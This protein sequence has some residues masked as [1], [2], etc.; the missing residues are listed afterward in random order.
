MNKRADFHSV[1]CLSRYPCITNSKTKP[2]STMT[3][4]ALLLASFSELHSIGGTMFMYPLSIMFALN[5]GLIVYG[6]YSVIQ[7]KSIDQKWLVVIKQIGGLAAAWGAW[8]TII[9]FYFAL[10]A[11]ESAQPAIPM[12]VI[13]GGTKVALITVLYGLLILCVS[14]LGSTVLRLVS[15]PV[16][17]S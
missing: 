9:G 17:A 13:A 3:I 6:A 7:K 4:N 8:S 1:H 5:I 2:L 12:N 11:I 14:V 15:R 16:T 10:D